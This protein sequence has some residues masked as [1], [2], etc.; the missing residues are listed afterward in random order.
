MRIDSLNLTN[1]KPELQELLKNL[2]IGDSVKGRLVEFLNNTATIKTSTGQ[3]LTA[4]LMTDL[5]I[6]KGDFVELMISNITEEGVFAELKPKEQA[7]PDKTAK[8][9]ELLS[10][11]QLPVSEKGLEAAELLLKYNLPINK[12]TMTEVLNTQKG[13]SNLAEGSVESKLGLLLSGL[14]VNNTELELLVKAAIIT[15][16]ELNAVKEKL[17]DSKPIEAD[18]AQQSAKDNEPAMKVDQAQAEVNKLGEA[19]NQ[20]SQKGEAI[21]ST[22]KPITQNILKEAAAIE[23]EMLKA[24]EQLKIPVS[25]EAKALIGGIAKALSV[26]GSANIEEAVYLL[27]KDIEI[28]PKNLEQVKSSI[29][30]ENKLDDFL[31]KLENQIDTGNKALKEVKEDIKKLF[32]TPKQLEDKEEVQGKLKDI[33]KLGEKLENILKNERL[34]DQ[35]VKTTL[36]NLRDNIEFIRNINNHNSYLQIPVLVNGEKSTADVYVMKDKKKG[37]T[38][39]PYNATVLVALDLKNLGHIESLISVVKKSVNVTFRIEDKTIGALI[40]SEAKQLQIALE[41]KGFSLSPVK[42]IKL[43]QTFNLISLEEMINDASKE[44]L[45]FDMRV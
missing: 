4:V 26:I 44:K 29:K 7:P 30:N 40:Q 10:K 28:T 34:P 24:L 23:Q 25:S 13:M 15:E 22:A 33:I 18:K 2:E 8:L 45:H 21:T 36:A 32:L 31:G 12:E 1:I 43:E 35:E 27:S 42:V 5:P 9:T 38:I 14:D 37:K 17:T 6:S 41:A 19:I 3:T 39:D 20:N 11:L 16:Q